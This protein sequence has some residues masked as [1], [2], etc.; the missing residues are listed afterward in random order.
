MIIYLKS[1]T[2]LNYLQWQDIM[3]MLTKETIFLVFL[4]Y[5]QNFIDSPY[6]IIF[7]YYFRY[8]CPLYYFP[9]HQ[10]ASKEKAL[11]CFLNCCKLSE[12]GTIIYLSC[13]ILY[14]RKQFYLPSLSISLDSSW[15]NASFY[16]YKEESKVGLHSS[17]L[18]Y[19]FG[20]A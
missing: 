20:W 3:K 7:T 6:M 2:A 5:Y 4:M 1:M 13:N 16:T 12:L 17:M 8:V 10:M 9:F 19:L 11:N 18:G 14:Y 15:K